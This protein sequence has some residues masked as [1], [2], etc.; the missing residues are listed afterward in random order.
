MDHHG[1]ADH[2]HDYRHSA[3][4]SL[5]IALVIIATFL[6]VS[7]AAQPFPVGETTVPVVTAVQGPAAANYGTG[8][9]LDLTV[10]FNKPVVV[11]PGPGGAVPLLEV[12]VGLQSQLIDTR[13]R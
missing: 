13:W 6:A 2:Y 7:L 1:Y 10:Q 12:M 3:R 4:G 8:A 9:A 5:K 11:T